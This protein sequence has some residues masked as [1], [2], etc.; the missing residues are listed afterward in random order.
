MMTLSIAE[1]EAGSFFS[2]P[3]FAYLQEDI[4]V[5]FFRIKSPVSR[6]YRRYPLR[7]LTRKFIDNDRPLPIEINRMDIYLKGLYVL[8]LTQSILHSSTILLHR[9][10]SKFVSNQHWFEI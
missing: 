9:M 8:K 10:R 6:L 3:S 4:K 5:T 2:F 1:P 7:R